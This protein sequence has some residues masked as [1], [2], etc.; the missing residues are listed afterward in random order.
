MYDFMA[1]KQRPLIQL[2][3]MNVVNGKLRK[4]NPDRCGT[5]KEPETRLPANDSMLP[6]SLDLRS[7]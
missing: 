3:V 2:A 6:P 5:T 1:S 4:N 7:L